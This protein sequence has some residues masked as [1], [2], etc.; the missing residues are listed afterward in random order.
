[1]YEL[2]TFAQF[3]HYTFTD[4]PSFLNLWCIHYKVKSMWTPDHVDIY[5][6]WAGGTSHT[7]TRGINMESLPSLHLWVWELILGEEVWLKT[8][9]SFHPKGVHSR[10]TITPKHFI[11]DFWLCTETESCWNRK[12]P[13]L[14]CCHEFGSMQLSKFSLYAVALTLTLQW[15]SPNPENSLRPLFILH[16]PS[17][18][19]LCMC[20]VYFKSIFLTSIKTRFVYQTLP[21]RAAWLINPENTFLLLQRAV[22]YTTPANTWH[23]A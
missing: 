17:Q 2:F 4:V 3:K 22:F 8:D 18:L 5:C 9:A 14:N 6:V 10:F 23:C 13:S 21:D 16:Q 12:R 15:L 11:M 1:M 19:A 20:Y 7:K